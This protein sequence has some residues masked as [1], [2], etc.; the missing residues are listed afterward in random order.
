MPVAHIKLLNGETRRS[1]AE[2]TIEN[3]YYIFKVVD[4]ANGNV[5]DTIQC[6]MGAAEDFFRMITYEKLPIFNPL[7]GDIDG[8]RWQRA[9]RR[10]WRR[11]RKTC[12]DL[13][14][15]SRAVI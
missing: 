6:G 9:T 7:V 8:G 4:R 3:E 13:E 11:W 14:S 15:I 5:I 1:D 10:R 2:A 12:G